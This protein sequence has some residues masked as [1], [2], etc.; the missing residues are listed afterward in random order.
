M[1]TKMET[2][3]AE[4]NKTNRGFRFTEWEKKDGSKFVIQKSSLAFKDCVWF[5]IDLGHGAT[6]TIEMTQPEI[7]EMIP[8]LQWFVKHGD[9][10][11][12]NEEDSNELELTLYE[13][14]CL[15]IEKHE[16]EVGEDEAIF[17]RELIYR[18]R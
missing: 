7:Q 4:I 2:D 18:H 13:R 10:D 16:P 6:A 12:R 17:L 15:L 1:I 11:I 8:I 3:M 14:L 5:R 9:V